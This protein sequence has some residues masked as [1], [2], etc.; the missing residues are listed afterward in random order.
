MDKQHIFARIL[1]RALVHLGGITVIGLEA[2]PSVPQAVKIGGGDP[3]QAGE[4]GA[5]RRNREGLGEVGICCMYLGIAGQVLAA[6]AIVEASIGGSA[7][8]PACTLEA[9]SKVA[10]ALSLAVYATAMALIRGSKP[11]VRGAAMMCAQCLLLAWGDAA[12]TLLPESLSGRVARA[13]AFCACAEGICVAGVDSRVAGGER[14]PEGILARRTRLVLLA[15]P[16]LRVVSMVVAGGDARSPVYVVFDVVEP[17]WLCLLCY[18]QWKKGRVGRGPSLWRTTC[19]GLFAVAFGR[20]AEGL[21]SGVPIPS[22]LPRMA[23][24]LIASDMYARYCASMIHGGDLFWV[25]VSV[26]DT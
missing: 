12:R 9:G 15:F 7:T 26:V 11:M 19:A 21:P 2:P 10:I 16:L 13:L 25:E 5:V 8:T 4:P 23:G 20:L 1:N 24:L 18:S 17:L 22:M 14:M 3:E 6:A